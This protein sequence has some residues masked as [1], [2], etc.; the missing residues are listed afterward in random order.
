MKMKLRMEMAD[1]ISATIKF[2][3]PLTNR[4]RDQTTE[5]RCS[6]CN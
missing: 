2:E 5:L 4:K 6:S 1:I 3:H